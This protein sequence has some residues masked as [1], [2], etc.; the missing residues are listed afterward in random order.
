M[1]TDALTYDD[2]F[3]KCDLHYMLELDAQGRLAGGE[4]IDSSVVSPDFIWLPRTRLAQE[5]K[6]ELVYENV[7]A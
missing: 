3:E 1:R 5:W 7:R 2:K 6:G 4:W